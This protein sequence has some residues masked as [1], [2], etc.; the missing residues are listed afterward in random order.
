[1]D[2]LSAAGSSATRNLTTTEPSES[3]NRRK[4]VDFRFQRPHATSRSFFFNKPM[5]A[6][7]SRRDFTSKKVFSGYFSELGEKA[8]SALQLATVLNDEESGHFQAEKGECS[9]SE[10]QWQLFFCIEL[11]TAGTTGLYGLLS[12]P[13]RY[14]PQA[15]PVNFYS[16]GPPAGYWPV[17]VLHARTCSAR[18]LFLIIYRG[19]V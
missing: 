19:L 5:R 13:D 3:L 2:H 15:F 10:P 6:M 16:A 9:V 18:A 12:S 7:D 4:T 14:I 8:N 17:P 11:P 1:M